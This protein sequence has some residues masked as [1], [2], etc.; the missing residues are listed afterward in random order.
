[1]QT[2][3]TA[4]LLVAEAYRATRAR[5]A[6]ALA[7][8]VED[9]VGWVQQGALGQFDDSYARWFSV[10][11]VF[12]ALDLSIWDIDATGIDK[13]GLALAYLDYF[14]QIDLSRDERL[15]LLTRAR[16]L[17]SPTHYLACARVDLERALL[18]STRDDTG[19][20]VEAL[21]LC[22][23]AIRCLEQLDDEVALAEAMYRKAFVL[24]SAERPVEASL[25]AEKAQRI[26]EERD[27]TQPV[28]N[29]CLFLSMVNVMRGRIPEASVISAEAIAGFERVGD[30]VGRARALGVR[31]QCWMAR[32]KRANAL[33]DCKEAVGLFDK[34]R[35]RAAQG[36]TL[37]FLANLELD[38]GHHAEARRSLEAAVEY[39]RESPERDSFVSAL[40]KLA[41]VLNRAGQISSTA[42]T[43]DEVEGHCSAQ[44]GIEATRMQPQVRLRLLLE[45]CRIAKESCPPDKPRLRRVSAEAI[46]L[47]R[48][49]PLEDLE[50]AARQ[51]A[52]Y[53]G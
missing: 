17:L 49:L 19:C 6:G 45:V 41:D 40:L 26:F 10:Q 28:A 1:M 37:S 35:M 7:N 16:G 22:D 33:R 50:T 23:E 11:P 53:A 18:L 13:V 43:L 14:R 5:D 8:A 29:V 46:R 44:P 51:Y 34:A 21:Y 4:A 24:L 25:E 30:S 27:M 38:Q 39:L 3:A 52:A 32:G 31:A 47:A 36:G 9:L 20:L 15:E 48:E 12:N 42:A 2:H